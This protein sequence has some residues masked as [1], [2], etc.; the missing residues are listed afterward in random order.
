MNALY[1]FTIPWQ[2][3]PSIFKAESISR[4]NQNPKKT[5]FKYN[6]MDKTQRLNPPW[7]PYSC[8][9][10]QKTSLSDTALSPQNISTLNSWT[11]FP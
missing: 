7:T 4:H 1:Y 8:N 3:F 5:H 11:T 2:P 9:T 6:N 10:S